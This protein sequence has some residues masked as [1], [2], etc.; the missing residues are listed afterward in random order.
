MSVIMHLVVIFCMRILVF[1]A[2]SNPNINKRISFVPKILAIMREMLAP[3][4][5]AVLLG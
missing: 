3:M 2:A 5:V 4:M 1:P